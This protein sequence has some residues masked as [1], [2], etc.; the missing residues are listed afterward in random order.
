MMQKSWRITIILFPILMIVLSMFL[1][2]ELLNVIKSHQTW[3][4]NF[5]SKLKM[6]S[7]EQQPY[8]CHWSFVNYTPNSWENMWYD[9]IGTFQTNVCEQLSND[10][11]LNKTI[12]MIQLIT[13]LQKSGRYDTS[14]EQLQIDNIF[15]TMFYRYECINPRTL[16]T[17]KII[18]VSHSIEPLI[19]LLRDP[20]SIC[21]RLH[22]SIVPLSLY[23]G[24]NLQSKRSI[25]LSVSAPFYTHS[26]LSDSKYLNDLSVISDDDNNNNN[27]VL[28]WMYQRLSHTNI[29][30]EIHI[31]NP[32]VILLDLGSSYFNGWK[33]DTTAAAGQW[34]YEYYK[35][36]NVKFDRIIAFEFSLLDQ[37]I[38]W[39]E[40][41]DDV[42]PIYTFI[43]VGVTENG[44]FNPWTMLKT[45]AQPFDHIIVKLD[46]D[47]TVL[48]N[49]L[50]NQILT[51]PSIH[52]LIDELL[53]EHHVTINE[54]MPYWGNMGHSLKGSLEDSYILFTKLRQLGIRAHSWP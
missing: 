38:V 2:H 51:D 32:K 13:M 52:T 20:F 41:P 26:I 42:F 44:K 45:I 18:E 31:R 53:F 54:M 35:R 24:A 36:F 30:K 16:R 9:N 14:I 40:L 1:R 43:N 4:L 37:E 25:L 29:D 47:T 34:L 7:D 5:Y 39:K 11:N 10:E 23:D 50:I 33:S 8:N 6:N 46:I 49:V 27:N 15:S 19:G 21:S 48:E 17:S 12:L 22:T 3:L 28:P